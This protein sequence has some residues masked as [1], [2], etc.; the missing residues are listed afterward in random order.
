ME[1]RKLKDDH[2]II[3]SLIVFPDDEPIIYL[4]V[5]TFSLSV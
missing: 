4:A 5:T 1:A 3:G 2:R